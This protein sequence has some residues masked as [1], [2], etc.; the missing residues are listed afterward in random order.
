LRYALVVPA[1]GSGLRFQ[2]RVP[3]QYAALL[4][5]RVVE[6]ALAPFLAD[7]RCESI[8]VVTAA[9]DAYWPDIRR[10]L[11]AA[12]KQLI[13]CEGDAQRFQSVRRGLAALRARAPVTDDSWVLVHDAV[14]PC[15]AAAQID[16]LIEALESAAG[17]AGAL[18]A[19][20]VTD[21]LK[22]ADDGRSLCTVSRATLWRAQTPQAFQL[23]ALERALDAAAASGRVPTDEAEAIEWQGSKPLLV[24]GATSNIKI[25]TPADLTL[26]AALLQGSNG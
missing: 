26:A 12:G 18:L 1:S 4:G 23:A 19:V 2:Q 5:R 3:K 8:C 16:R 25:T 11:D 14:R 9:A 17:A 24:P 20:P 21:T 13:D 22:Q 7:R 10:G 6:W 15:I